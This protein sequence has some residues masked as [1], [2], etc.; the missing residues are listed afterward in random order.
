MPERERMVVY[1]LIA[2][3][4]ASRG[5]AL[6]I[7]ISIIT[8]VQVRAQSKLAN[9]AWPA[10]RHN[11]L[12]T[13]FTPA[14]G[15]ALPE[16]KWRANFGSGPLG[17]PVLAPDGTIYVPGNADSALYAVTPNGV[18]K[19]VFAG[20]DTE[21][22]VAPLIVGEDGTLY[23]G[24]TTNI[25]YA[26]NSIGSLRWRLKLGGPVRFS[27]NIGSDG[28]IYVA[29]NDCNLYA[30]TPA[31]KLKWKVFLGKLPGNG[32][33]LANDGTIYVVAGEF[34]K[35]FKPDGTLRLEFTNVDMGLLN[36]LMV[37][38]KELFYVTALEKPFIRAISNTPGIRWEQTLNPSFKGSTMP[39]MGKDG[40]IYFA[41][42]ENG[43]VVA[44]NH[45]GSQRWIFSL[46][47]AK[48]LTE[49]V[50]DDSNYVYIVNDRLGLTSLSVTGKLRWSLP[51]VRCAFSPAIGADGTIYVA[52]DRKLYAIGPQPPRADSLVKLSDNLEAC[53]GTPVADTIRARVLDQYGNVFPGRAVEF[54][55]LSGG[56]QVTVLNGT[57]DGN[58][59][60]R[61]LWQLGLARGK[62]EL[63][64]ASDG[65]SGSPA[66]FTATAKTPQISGNREAAFDSPEIN[67]IS[68]KIHFIRNNS[69]CTLRVDS[70]KIV[71]GTASVFSV[72][73]PSFPQTIKAGDNLAVRLRFGPTECSLQTAT[74]RLFSDD[75]DRS[76]FDVSLRG[77]ALARPDISVA[78]TPLTFGTICRDTTVTLS[79]PVSNTGCADLTIINTTSTNAAFVVVTP[80]PV[81]IP[82]GGQTLLDIRFSPTAVIDYN[83]T[84]SIFSNDPDKTPVTVTVSGSG[85]EVDIAGATA[86]NFDSVEVQ[87]CSGNTNFSTR[88]YVIRNTGFC[89]LVVN[90]P[91]TVGVVVVSPHGQQII[92]PGDSLKVELKFTPSLLGEF[93]G[94]FRITNN[95]P[96]KSP[97][98]VG[99]HG[100]G[101]AAPAIALTPPDTLDFDKVSV[102]TNKRLSVT[103]KNL[104]AERLS[105]DSLVIKSKN[106]STEPL[107]FSLECNQ[108]KSVDVAFMP[109]G[110]GVFID[111]LLIYS[112]DPN[113]NASK[114][115]M[116]VMVAL[117][118]N[119][120][121]P[122]RFGPTARYQDTGTAS[123]FSQAA[124]EKP[125]VL[126]L[127]GIGS[128][129]DIA[130]EPNPLDFGAVCVGGDSLMFVAIKN[131]GMDTLFVNSLIFSDTAFS[132]TQV[133]PFPVLPGGSLAVPIAF[134][135]QD[136]GRIV[137]T[138]EIRSN[139][140]DENPVV[141]KL[142]AEGI[143][144]LIAIKTTPSDSGDV[145]LGQTGVTNVC[146]IN[147]GNCVL[148][149]D[150]V[151]F[152]LIPLKPG[153][154]KTSQNSFSRIF[155]APLFLKPGEENCVFSFDAAEQTNNF[156]VRVRVRSNA[157]N[158]DPVN[159]FIHWT[160]VQPII[161]SED[162]VAFD[163]V[164]V[165]ESIQK[166]ARVWNADSCD[167]RIDSLKIK[168]GKAS[169]FSLGAFVVP[170]VLKAGDIA[171]IP[172]I[173]APDTVGRHIDTLLVF[174][175]DP[176]RNPLKIALIGEGVVEGDQPL[177]TTDSLQY[178]FDAVCLDGIDS[179]SV[180]VTNIGNTILKVDSV[181]VQPKNGLFSTAIVSFSLSPGQSKILT[182]FFT[183]PA[184]GT[185]SAKLQIFSNATNNTAEN[186]KAY[187]AA[188]EGKSGAAVIAVS[189]TVADF[190]T[191]E[192]QTCAGKT[193]S[194]METLVIRNEGS[195][196]LVV[197]LPNP[198]GIFTVDSPTGRQVIPPGG[199]LEVTLKF[200]PTSPGD[201]VD[202][203]LIVSND[204]DKSTFVVQLRG[205][206]VKQPDIEVKPLV[207]DFDSVAVENS[208][209]LAV[210][211]KNFG[212]STLVVNRLMI[213]SPAFTTETDEF[214]LECNDSNAVII[215]FT[216]T[217]ER[218]YDDTLSIFSNDPDENPVVVL[219]RGKGVRTVV[220]TDSLQY[221]FGVVCLGDTADLSVVVTNKGN[222][223]LKV[224]S[225]RVQPKN[226][227]FSTAADSFSLAPGQSKTLTVSFAP[228][229][230]GMYSAKLQIFGNATNNNA[231]NGKA[232]EV[233]LEGKS[234]ASEIDGFSE[235]TFL[236]TKVDS[237]RS[238][239]YFVNNLGTC[240]L[241]VIS[242]HIEGK[243]P[244]DFRVK[245]GL[246]PTIAPG[247]FYRVTLEFQPREPGLREAELVIKSNDPLRPEFRVKL[248]G[249]GI[250][251]P[252]I[253]V[254]PQSLGYPPVCLG[255]DS[256]LC[257]KVW[258][259][260]KSDLIV[261]KVI[262][263][264]H[265]I[266]QT[267]AGEFQLKPGD[268]TAICVIFTPLDTVEYNGTL[269]LVSNAANDSN[270]VVPLRGR[271]IA[272]HIA[273]ADTLRF[274]D[275]GIDK[276][277]T[278]TY[279][280]N[281]D[282]HCDLRIDKMRIMC[283][284]SADFR[285][286]NNPD[287]SYTIAPN[288]KLNFD[289]EFSPQGT[290]IRERAAC[291]NI[292]S[293]DPT[294]QPFVVQ[295]RGNG[296][297]GI[298]AACDTIDFGDTCADNSKTLTCTLKN[299]HPN[300]DVEIVS[301]KLA[302]GKDYF[303]PDSIAISSAMPIRL[304]PDSSMNIRITFKPK[305]DGPARPGNDKLVIKTKYQ[306]QEKDVFYTELLGHK[307]SDGPELVL[308]PPDSIKFVGVLG[309]ETECRPAVIFNNGCSTLVVSNL[310][311]LEL[312]KDSKLIDPAN[313]FKLCEGSETSFRLEPGESKAVN[314]LFRGIDFGEKNGELRIFNDDPKANP[315]VVE[316]K[317]EVTSGGICLEPDSSKLDFG[318]VYRRKEKTIRLG[319]LNC[320][321]PAALLSVKVLRSE[322]NEQN[323]TDNERDFT[324]TPDSLPQV[325]PKAKQYLEI[326][327]RPTRTGER[328][329]ELNLYVTSDSS[330]IKREKVIPVELHGFGIDDEVYARPNAF[331][332]NDD[333]K[334]DFAKIHFPGYKM[335]APVLR[336][337]DLRGI[338]VR[339]LRR[340]DNGGDEIA[341][342]GYDNESRG[343]LMPPGAYVWLLED[344]GKKVGSGV[345]VLIR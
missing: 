265:P 138:L 313:V 104:G 147:V 333:D 235:L 303:L 101:I 250:G 150:S 137:G 278:K 5:V 239:F 240:P 332:P 260:G 156:A 182:V 218:A 136:T 186:G 327:F 43:G 299:K 326:T 319:L 345:I 87:T 236:P 193:N 175:N 213:S 53:V 157:V 204:P 284:D 80:L 214:S 159:R 153:S 320:S 73:A 9:S 288:G 216:P 46:S 121:F 200:T 208:K 183:P 171:N 259:R 131:K 55:V 146:V 7:A 187:E 130:V 331:T 274:P 215:A 330:G 125:A 75:P 103:I 85:G 158:E 45:D 223:L 248:N 191:V 113:G 119:E 122:M 325:T 64:V 76:Q 30:I 258:N 148:R 237:I 168:G 19:W 155:A 59:I 221:R 190:G 315:T 56:G 74:L 160:V 308:L 285:L 292:W 14:K 225:V 105:V 173:F 302:S 126:Y 337:Y 189:P 219:L 60:A 185:Y 77:A 129:P 88:F 172:V 199:N 37:E 97:L 287:S 317:G 49:L 336:I 22:F 281:G 135:P 58:G 305:K 2:K 254:V 118:E 149:V 89:D 133:T 201:F 344:Q 161:A 286:L 48:N 11:A 261:D 298:L 342:D 124:N 57:T 68:E 296:V 26:I 83:S 1:P 16:V 154:L 210:T 163:T 338:A 166:N 230:A 279:T 197:D 61:A 145:C 233:A 63:E 304:G 341:W 12:M 177:I 228:P 335:V 82:P 111:S 242:M 28:T 311:L 17:S 15:P 222:A 180:K 181:R 312:T 13:A 291:L 38:G 321:D 62:Q 25:F 34:L 188:L 295:L 10:F 266:F 151:K 107:E 152:V 20:T 322:P 123:I 112:N 95:V 99:L 272:P 81:V 340:P 41:T 184:R 132:T 328:R 120:K 226:G 47:G 67:Q 8:S 35:G 252:V 255:E 275:T 282:S 52:S 202:T 194:A 196:N 198:V 290:D 90:L 323:S 6:I 3:R 165:H 102:G 18:L 71:G 257:V 247:G 114:R 301:L 174:N 44:L 94:T 72:L 36:G 224:D 316:L 251:E 231:E 143:G 140:P 217:E 206:G 318:K 309:K 227:I 244:N 229:Y 234:G 93:A 268:S 212:D 207:L 70:L 306:S 69:E 33:A 339:V 78:T 238:N 92:K 134:A 98:L 96:N 294:Q 176:K 42:A 167:V 32:P 110:Q 267:E 66:I 141:V 116:L 264:P 293:D 79:L 144:P 220:G 314:V 343:R 324:V 256:T 24:S 84:L 51:E 269:T 329:D 170:K 108:S 117:G 142:L 270:I 65:L 211:V 205:R 280:V 127:H 100:R 91:D 23:F 192:I 128:G 334:N 50:V 243:H 162:S 39:A 109:P 283:A 232:Y 262:A 31:G 245:D 27:A 139:D 209:K 297:T 307:K 178:R 179:L 86:V 169:A 271:G 164:Q 310:R 21:K 4:T 203:L 195:C 263:A 249:N 40:A 241:V 54:R 106:F 300:A 29:A 289:V 273:G 253:E 276:T 246:M 115:N 277:S